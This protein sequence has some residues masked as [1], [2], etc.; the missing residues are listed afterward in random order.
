MASRV[1][2]LTCTEPELAANRAGLVHADQ[3]ARHE[4][5]L[6]SEQRTAGFFLAVAALLIVGGLAFGVHRAAELDAAFPT[7]PPNRGVIGASVF[8]GAFLALLPVLLGVL[9]RRECS[10]WVAAWS[11]PRVVAVTGL[12]RHE[13]RRSPKGGVRHCLVIGSHAYWIPEAVGLR[14]DVDPGP[15]RAYAVVSADLDE[16][17]AYERV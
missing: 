7:L 3:Q 9:I 8:M 16:L 5:Q 1:F 17:I 15:Y 4:Q 2:E 11:E 10:A 6:Q 13:L 14:F 12:A